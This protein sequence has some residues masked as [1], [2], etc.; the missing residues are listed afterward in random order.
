M[1]KHRASWPELV[2]LTDSGLT[3]R[4]LT[5]ERPRAFLC[6]D[7]CV[8]LSFVG[9]LTLRLGYPRDAWAGSEEPC[10]YGGMPFPALIQGKGAWSC[11]N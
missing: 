8:D 4:E 2:R 11:V 5:W 7:S 9:H 1:G 10:P 3:A 6:G